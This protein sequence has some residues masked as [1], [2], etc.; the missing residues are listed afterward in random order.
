MFRLSNH[1]PVLSSFMTYHGFVTR[2]KRRGPLVEQILLTLLESTPDFQWVRVAQIA[3]FCVEFCRSLLGLVLSFFFLASVLSV[4]QF[5]AFD[6]LCDNTSN[7]S[8]NI[9]KL[10]LSITSVATLQTVL[11]IS[12]T[13]LYILLQILLQHQTST[14]IL[15]LHWER[16]ID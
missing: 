1:Y 8:D 16:Y 7:C 6:Y 10:R 11:I 9:Y 15:F 14:D 2:V 4:Y 3:V 12:T 13:S 5:T